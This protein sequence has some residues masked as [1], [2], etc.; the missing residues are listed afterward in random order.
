[1]NRTNQVFLFYFYFIFILFLFYFF[2]KLALEFPLSIRQPPAVIQNGKLQD[3]LYVTSHTNDT[4][5]VCPGTSNS[6]VQ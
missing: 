1:M 5:D 3:W 4:A 2:S 6:G